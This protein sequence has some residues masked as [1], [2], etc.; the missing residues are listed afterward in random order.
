MRSR[1]LMLRIF[2]RFMRDECVIKYQ[3]VRIKY[4]RNVEGDE[5]ILLTL[6]FLRGTIFFQRTYFAQVGP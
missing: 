2:G 4:I 3:Q 6:K 1:R 5:R